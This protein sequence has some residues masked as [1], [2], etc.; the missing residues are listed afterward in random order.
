MTKQTKLIKFML[1][2]LMLIP[3]LLFSVAIVQTFVLK[4][5]HN[6]LL[7]AKNKLEQSEQELT[8]QQQIKDYVFELDENGNYVISKEYQEALYKHNQENLYGKQ[9]DVNVVIK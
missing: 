1:I 7:N 5:A 8:K 2:V 4:D 9:D 6:K 3:L